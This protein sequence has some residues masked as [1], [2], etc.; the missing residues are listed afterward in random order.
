MTE[1]PAWIAF[2]NPDLQLRLWEKMEKHYQENYVKEQIKEKY[3]K[4]LNAHLPEWVK[5]FVELYT[6]DLKY[7]IR[8]DLN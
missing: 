8:K 5:K 7:K 3:L 1:K 6:S 2:G 4:D